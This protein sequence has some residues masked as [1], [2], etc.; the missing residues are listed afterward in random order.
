MFKEQ[1]AL[2]IKSSTPQSERGGGG[3]A[4]TFEHGN[5]FFTSFFQV[6]SVVKAVFGIELLTKNSSCLSERRA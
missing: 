5:G 2:L 3:G 6:K 4:A 1:P